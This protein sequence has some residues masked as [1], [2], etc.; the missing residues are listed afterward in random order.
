[1][2]NLSPPPRPVS[3]KF[4]AHLGPF[5]MHKIEINT[6][7]EANNCALLINTATPPAA[8]AAAVAVGAALAAAP[9]TAAFAVTCAAFDA[10]AIATVYWEVAHLGDKPHKR[11]LRVPVALSLCLPTQH[12]SNVCSVSVVLSP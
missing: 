9:G 10:A 12:L 1:M 7:A 3:S 6:R 11:R 5:N 4:K 2:Q 8:A